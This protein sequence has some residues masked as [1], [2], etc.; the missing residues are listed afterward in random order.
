MRANNIELFRFSSSD[1]VLNTMRPA[2]QILL[3]DRQINDP[4]RCR[5]DMLPCHRTL[6][7]TISRQTS[8]IRY[9]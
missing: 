6:M 1:M 4:P 3:A 5:H 2:P 7:H 9:N 8:G